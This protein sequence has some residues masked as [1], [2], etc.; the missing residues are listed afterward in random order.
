MNDVDA[1]SEAGQLVDGENTQ[2]PRAKPEPRRLASLSERVGEVLSPAPAPGRAFGLQDLDAATG[3]L[4][5]G[6]LTLV[7]AAPGAG[8]SLLALA[9]ARHTA[10]VED[11]PVLYAAAGLTTDVVTRWIIAAEAGVDL[12]R[13]RA[14]T[15]TAAEREA[16][17]VAGARVSQARVFFDDGASL[18]AEAIAETAPYVDDLALVVVDRLHHAHD[19]HIPLSGNHVPPAVRALT[20]LARQLS[21]PVLAVLNTDDADALHSLDPDVTLTLG[22]ADDSGIADVT[23]AER[24]LGHTTIRLRADLDHARFTDA[25][26]QPASPSS[27]STPPQV[28]D[29]TPS[30]ADA[31]LE[32]EQKLIEA[33]LPFTAGAVRGLPSE[34]LQLLADHRDTVIN[35]VVD[36]LPTV[37]AYSAALASAAGLILPGTREGQQLRATLDAFAVAHRAEAIPTAVEP[38]DGADGE[39]RDGQGATGNVPTG[40]TEPGD[41]AA[42][43]QQPAGEETAEQEQDLQPGDEEDEPKE[44]VFPALVILKDAVGRSKMHPIKVIRTEERDSGPWPLISEHMDGEPR[45]VHPDVTSDARRPHQRANGKR[46]RRDQLDVPDSFGDGR[47]VPDRPQR[48]LPLGLFSRPARPEQA[49]AHRP[50]GSVRQEPGRHLPH[51]HPR[52]EPPRMPHPLGRIIDRPTNTAGCGSP[53]RTS[54]SSNARPRRPHRTRMPAIHDSWTGKAN[55]SLFKPF[56]AGR[57][58]RHAPSS[59]RP[60]ASPTRRTRPGCRSRCVC[61]GPSAPEQRSPF[62]RPDWRMSMV[63]EASVRHW[64]AAFKAVQ[65]GHRLIAL[66]NVDAAVFWTPDRHGPRPRTGSGPAS[67]K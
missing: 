46:V 25:P 49:P 54:S 50:P 60:A 20:H 59:S 22:A 6:R 40:E 30:T 29:A 44:A 34:A 56:Y 65:E 57:P 45:W 16:A 66:R 67:A 43:H 2:V 13:L 23:V 3:G 21:V 10:L 53:P 38:G 11:S 36:E 17:E 12:R 35:E 8:G 42:H 64:I 63:A 28:P 9:A 37:R 51:R 55:E 18:T 14:G 7:A 24:D 27:L 58:R 32:A 39:E 4:Q 62:W 26:S 19:P 1:N 5:P 15:L 61:C 33:A 41:A 31:L 52:V 48:L 47:D